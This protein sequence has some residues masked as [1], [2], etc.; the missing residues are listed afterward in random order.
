M[1]N[2]PTFW[3]LVSAVIIGNVVYAIIFVLV[4]VLVNALFG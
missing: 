3:T 4:G 1:R 2:L